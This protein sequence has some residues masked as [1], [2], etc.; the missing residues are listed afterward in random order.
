MS[1]PRTPLPPAS[2]ALA[3]PER[4]ISIR[5]PWAWLIL[6]D[7]RIENRRW[8]TKYRGPLLIH[9][10]K[11]MAR[12]EYDDAVAYAHDVAPDIVV[13]P[14]ESLP[15]GGVVGR[16][17]LI[18]V[19]APHTSKPPANVLRPGTPYLHF[20]LDHARC[21]HRYHMPSQ[22]GFVLADVEELPFFPMR[23]ALQIFRVTPAELA[24]LAQHIKEARHAAE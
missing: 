6:R 5:Q 18:D 23:G 21:E 22:F 15:R 17:R 10:A 19:I 1:D 12:D 8:A 16:A 3:L 24:R 20:P 13:P 14:F 7:K 11:G 4:A 9:A 2:D